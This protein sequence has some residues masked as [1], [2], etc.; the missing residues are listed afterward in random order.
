MLKMINIIFSTWFEIW[1]W[2]LILN[3]L[4]IRMHFWFLT[5]LWRY[6]CINILIIF[7]QF[8]SPSKFRAVLTALKYIEAETKFD[9]NKKGICHSKTAIEILEVPAIILY[10]NLWNMSGK[11]CYKVQ[12]CLCI[13]LS[14]THF[15]NVYYCL[16][17]S[18]L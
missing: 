10:W 14:C 12:H 11:S 9:R 3:P 1:I 18:F 2:K 15:I 6:S 16:C 7:C 17:T 5:V 8:Q 13:L 4:K